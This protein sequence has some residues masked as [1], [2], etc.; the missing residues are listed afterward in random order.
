MAL[1]DRTLHFNLSEQLHKTLIKSP[2]NIA[3]LST[4]MFV[5]GDKTPITLRFYEFNINGLVDTFIDEEI[6]EVCARWES[7]NAELFTPAVVT[8]N[9]NGIGLSEDGELQ[10]GVDFTNDPKG[11]NFTKGQIYPVTQNGIDLGGKITATNVDVSGKLIKGIVTSAG[12]GYVLTD[13][14]TIEN[15]IG[16]PNP[17]NNQTLTN[18]FSAGSNIGDSDINTS[19][20]ALFA[21][22]LNIQSNADGLLAFTGQGESQIALGNNL[23]DYNNYEKK[24]YVANNILNWQQ[25]SHPS[26]GN[27]IDSLN[28]WTIPS[29]QPTTPRV[30]TSN[31]W[32]GNGVIIFADDTMSGL[33]SL[34]NTLNEP[35]TP[36]VYDLDFGLID[37]YDMGMSNPSLDISGSTDGTNFN[38]LVSVDLTY[39]MYSSS[40]S[41]IE[42]FEVPHTSDSITHIKV[43]YSPSA[44]PPDQYDYMDFEK[45]SITKREPPSG[46]NQE[47][48]VLRNSK[49]EHTASSIL[50]TAGTG[51]ISNTVNLSDEGNYHF[52]ITAKALAHDRILS[53]SYDFPQLYVEIWTLVNPSA[54]N[55]IISADIDM[56]DGTVNINN[57]TASTIAIQNAFGEIEIEIVIPVSSSNTGDYV[58][59]LRT[60]NDS[61]IVSDNNITLR[62]ASVKKDN[63]GAELLSNN[64]SIESWSVVN[65][66]DITIHKHPINWEVKSGSLD[67]TSLASGILKRASNSTKLVQQSYM[68]SYDR[69]F[70]PFLKSSQVY[71]LCL[72]LNDFNAGSTSQ[73]IIEFAGGTTI[74][75]ADGSSSH[76]FTINTADIPS[77]NYYETYFKTGSSMPSIVQ[78]ELLNADVEISDL[79]IKEAYDT[80]IGFS[81]HMEESLSVPDPMY[82]ETLTDNTL[83][84]IADS[85]FQAS[86]TQNL[87]LLKNN[88]YR[89]RAKTNSIYNTAYSNSAYEEANIYG[90]SEIHGWQKLG[91]MQIGQNISF[92]DS[93]LG[94][95]GHKF[96]IAPLVDLTALSISFPQRHIRLDEMSVD[97]NKNAMSL[98]FVGGSLILQVGNQYS[99]SSANISIPIS[100]KQVLTGDVT[101]SILIDNVI[102]KIQLYCDS[103]LLT[104]QAIPSGFSNNAWSALG[105]KITELSLNTGLHNSTSVFNG[106]LN[107][108]LRYYENPIPL[109]LTDDDI[110]EIKLESDYVSP[111]YEVLI[112]LDGPEVHALFDLGF[113]DA[114]A[115]FDVQCRD[116]ANT[117]IRTLARFDGLIFRDVNFNG[118]SGTPFTP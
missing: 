68:D 72:T 87:S 88:Q 114:L 37:F 83:R 118:S 95:M 20:S 104:E 74:T 27:V 65:P 60:I 66:S 102:N 7:T 47:R 64:N 49:F 40:P 48:Y 12:S 1:Q 43:A 75:W 51:G 82:E 35:L 26:T 9:I 56:E 5:Q 3:R 107:S 8:V 71:K 73:V 113:G 67:E 117:K 57:G 94:F 99:T 116:T 105:G 70:N 59:S 69:T 61:S 98:E 86:I 80:S 39:N 90:Y 97:A 54:S 30:G 42:R 101:L 58:F 15:P 108:G 109:S 89:I 50:T 41:T 10:G 19:A 33:D 106:Q 45:F 13:T 91:N 100:S 14:I 34:I 29:G 18:T 44:S 111:N 78:V 79:Q 23:G 63:V 28:G 85:P 21:I 110:E 6:I 53:S 81:T 38:N 112:N 52:K 17:E 62:N 92:S 31:S 11:G 93:S 77:S 16:D 96:D 76:S 46:W 115:K 36:G 4:A 22:D 24:Y 2:I 32:G 84:I 103:T 25:T 55:V